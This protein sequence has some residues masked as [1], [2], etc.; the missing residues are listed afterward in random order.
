M[1]TIEED[2]NNRYNIP[3]KYYLTGSCKLG[4]EC[5]FLH[6]KPKEEKKKNASL[7][8]I[9][10]SLNHV[11]QILLSRKPLL[12]L[13]V[14]FAADLRVRKY[15]EDTENLFIENGIH[16]Y[17]QMET[18][19]RE[20]IKPDNLLDIITQ[21]TSDYLVVI[22]DRN[23]KNKTC[24]AKKSGKLVEISVDERIE[25]IISEW[26]NQHQS[27]D[28]IDILNLQV[29]NISKS[30]I[31]EIIQLF[32]GIKHISDRYLRLKKVSQEMKNWTNVND[33]KNVTTLTTNQNA[34]IRLHK[35]LIYCLQILNEIPIDEHS[36]R[37]L[38]LASPEDPIIG[39]SELLKER[40]ILECQS[41]IPNIEKIG[42]NLSEFTN[43]SS[44]WIAYIQ[45]SKMK[46]KK[47]ENN[48][49]SSSSITT[50]TT[51]KSDSIPSSPDNFN[52]NQSPIKKIMNIQ[53][54]IKIKKKELTIDTTT[55]SKKTII[56]SPT[57]SWATQT[58]IKSPPNQT[59]EFDN[60][61]PS[62][63]GKNKTKKKEK[64]ILSPS[65][66][67]D[68]LDEKEENKTTKSYSNSNLS[69][70]SDLWNP[71]DTLSTLNFSSS[72]SKLSSSFDD[73]M[74]L[75][76]WSSSTDDLYDSNDF[77]SYKSPFFNSRK[78]TSKFSSNF[79]S[80][81]SSK[82]TTPFDFPSSHKEEQ[83][84]F[85]KQPRNRTKSE[86]ANVYYS[87]SNIK[88]PC[89]ICSKESIFECNFCANLIKKGVNLQKIFF[90]SDCMKTGW[91][92]HHKIHEKL[93]VEYKIFL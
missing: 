24:H 52:G 20:Y 10:D 8:G 6:E 67:F 38:S 54:D 77:N 88:K 53:K 31:L 60:Q 51:M 65:T 68:F 42:S 66:Q 43:N 33:E 84:S 32:T 49:S 9:R 40:L 46:K 25:T 58:V 34:C 30:Q 73:Q 23:M 93:S 5:K 55:N 11:S 85:M 29:E 86:P 82:P 35:D 72:F 59:K 4:K 81:T 12:H 28:K 39:I 48:V 1:T 3:C 61:F 27:N 47:K 19:N 57:V 76:K 87:N 41:M 90:C 71:T 69:D 56:S 92:N 64:E 79:S 80:F 21:S 78:E 44:L 18:E 14:L 13:V 50:T 45:E 62:L 16:V 75:G 22:G 26:D 15:A 7:Q 70:L 91:K 89:N 17:M 83:N 36:E 74:N 37:G 2:K 63:S